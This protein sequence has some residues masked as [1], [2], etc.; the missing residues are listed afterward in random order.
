MKV[1]RTKNKMSIETKQN[2]FYIFIGSNVAIVHIH[3]H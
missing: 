3:K 2:I 1:I